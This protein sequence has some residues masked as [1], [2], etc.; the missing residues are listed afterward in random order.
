MTRSLRLRICPASRT[1]QR[2]NSWTR[3]ASNRGVEWPIIASLC[4]R[5]FWSRAMKT[6]VSR[7][8]LQTLEHLLLKRQTTRR[9]LRTW[10]EKEAPYLRS[11]ILSS[12]PQ[13]KAP[14]SAMTS[15]KFREELPRYW[16]FPSLAAPPSYKNKSHSATGLPHFSIQRDPSKAKAEMR[17]LPPPTVPCPSTWWQ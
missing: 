7:D 3:T 15:I 14:T 6:E 12:K 11:R 2:T 4:R 5:G 9:P 8:S 16:R 1:T 10:T 17:L 13:I